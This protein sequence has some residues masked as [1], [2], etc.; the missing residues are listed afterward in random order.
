MKRLSFYVVPALTIAGLSAAAGA[1]S[2]GTAPGAQTR[3]NLEAAM[4]GEAYAHLKYLAYAEQ[5]RNSGQA[6]LARTFEDAANVEA[7]EHF[8]REAERLGLVGANRANLLDAMAGEHFEFSKMYLDYAR[9]AEQE[10]DT[11]SA[12]LFRQIA[13]DEQDHYARFKQQE[14]KLRA[15][16]SKAKGER[17]GSEDSEEREQGEK[18]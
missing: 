14:A 9:Q 18:S 12:E 3:K 4:H 2:A 16:D 11:Q 10:G 13:A 8:A 7:G 17:S 6:E 5:A 1:F 15:P